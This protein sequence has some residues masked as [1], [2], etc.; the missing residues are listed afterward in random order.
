MTREIIDTGIKLKVMACCSANAEEPR[1]AYFRLS[2][3]DREARR[4]YARAKYRGP[5][6]LVQKSKQYLKCL[7]AGLIQRC[8]ESTLVRHGITFDNGEYRFT[9]D[10]ACQP[11]DASRV[12]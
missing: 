5:A 2:P 10:P 6:G 7:R 4:A 3:E 9:E 8:K 11:T 1:S 12:G